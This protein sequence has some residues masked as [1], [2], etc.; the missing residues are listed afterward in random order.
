LDVQKDKH[1]GSR[2][3]D[4]IHAESHAIRMGKGLAPVRGVFAAGARRVCKRG[5]A[6]RYT[7]MYFL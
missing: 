1:A 5:A 3:L 7:F 2:S 4:P 6:R